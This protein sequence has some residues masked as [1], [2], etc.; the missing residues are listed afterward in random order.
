M[1]INDE[2]V[3]DEALIS[4]RFVRAPGPGGQKVNKVATAVQLRF[5]VARCRQIDDDT[6]QRL[7][8]AAGARLNRQGEIVITANRHRSQLRNRQDA[9]E[10]LARLIR[11][12]LIVPRKRRPPR[13]PS[14]ADST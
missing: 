6:R 2:L 13:K 8:A 12:A 3:I 11:R 5:A 4:E 1:H 10:R 9:R 14:A 7:V